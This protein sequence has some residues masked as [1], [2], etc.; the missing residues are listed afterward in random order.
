MLIPVRY[1]K[2]ACCLIWAAATFLRAY[3]Q[4]HPCC[5]VH[6]QARR[7]ATNIVLRALCYSMVCCLQGIRGFPARL[8]SLLECV[9]VRKQLI[10]FLSD[11]V[12]TKSRYTTSEKW[13]VF[14][15]LLTVWSRVKALALARRCTGKNRFEFKA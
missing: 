10:I 1:W 8:R 4:K 6:G 9:G 3:V 12:W 2:P 11:Y 7:P 15:L 13:Q 14:V 5:N